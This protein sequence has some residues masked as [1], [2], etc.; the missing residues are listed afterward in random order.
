M[1][2]SHIQ[3][4]LQDIRLSSQEAYSLSPF[5]YVIGKIS[6]TDAFYCGV[7]VWEPSG[8]PGEDITGYTVRI[9]YEVTGERTNSSTVTYMISN[10]ETRWLAPAALPVQRPLFYQ[11]SSYVLTPIHMQVHYTVY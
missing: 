6:I 3:L 10:K 1:R 11:V 7:I 4:Y 8:T 2:Y 9:F 5:P